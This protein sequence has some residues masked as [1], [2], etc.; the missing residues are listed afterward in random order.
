MSHAQRPREYPRLFVLSCLV[1]GLA[2]GTGERDL[3]DP[4]WR[5][6]ARQRADLRAA[7][8][9]EHSLCT[10]HPGLPCL[11]LWGW[12]TTPFYQR[13]AIVSPEYVEQRAVEESFRRGANLVEL[14]RGGFPLFAR[15]GW[16]LPRTRQ[17]HRFIHERDMLVQWFPHSITDAAFRASGDQ[18]F[19]A[20][21]QALVALG[22][23]SYDALL[24]PAEE[25]MDGIGSEKWYTMPPTLFNLCFW[26]FHPGTFY[27]TNFHRYS[28]TLPNEMD[29]TASSGLGVD[30]QTTTIPWMPN[31]PGDYLALVHEVRKEHGLQFWASQA[32]ARSHLVGGLFGGL[33]GPAWVLKQSNDICRERA[34]T[35][36]QRELS[37]SAIWWINEA[38]NV[39]P[40]AMREYV[41][42]ISQDP[43]R[44]AVSAELGSLGADAA[45]GSRRRALQRHAQPAATAF[46][47]NNYFRL[48]TLPEGDRN[49]LLHDPERLAHYD[50]DSRTVRLAGPLLETAWES[51]AAAHV[52]AVSFAHLE[53][54][55][56]RAVQE[57][58][59]HFQL[60]GGRFSETRT[61]TLESD[62][63]C[64]RLTLEREACHG[65]FSR[66][67]LPVY[68]RLR[69]DGRLHSTPT[70]LDPPPWM[71]LED[72]AGDYPALLLLLP[73]A[74]TLRRLEWVPREGLALRS[75]SGAE[76]FE[77]A[78]ALP[79]GLYAPD[80][81]GDLL[82]LLRRPEPALRLDD[83][84]RVVV[85]NPLPIPRVRVV[86]LEGGEVGPFH[87][88]EFGAWRV[89]GAQPSRLQPD[90]ALVK[91][92]LPPGGEAVVERY[93]W[94]GGAVRPGWGCQYTLSVHE[95]ESARARTRVRV[96]A[97][98]VTAFLFAPRLRFREPVA[99]VRLNGRPWAYFD[100][101]HV[102]LPN[103]RGSYRLEVW[104]GPPAVPRLASTFAAIE[105]ARSRSDRLDFTAGLPPWTTSLPEGF[106]FT[107]LVRHPGAEVTGLENAELVRSASGQASILRF[108][109][110]K[111][112]VAFRPSGTHPPLSPAVDM[113]AEAIRFLRQEGAEDLLPY[114]GAFQTRMISLDEPD[115]VA[116]IRN[117]D[118]LLFNPY[119]T[120]DLPANLTA[121]AR[122]AL[123]DFV[124]SGGGLL[125]FSNGVRLA[126]DLLGAPAGE[127]ALTPL[128][129]LTGQ[130]LES[131]GFLPAPEA[132]AELL[133]GLPR[134]ATHAAMIPLFRP[135]RFDFF[136]WLECRDFSDGERKGDLLG[137]VVCLAP[138]GSL[139]QGPGL[140]RWRLGQG[141]LLGHPAGLRRS[142]GS[143]DRYAP[144][145]QERRLVENL[146]GL[147][148]RQEN[149]NLLLGILW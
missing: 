122:S 79:E 74:G 34:R 111:V 81:Y 10:R 36:G 39:T 66:M 143:R 82:A 84:G 80:R 71:L 49:L 136:R 142:Y 40:D 72:S 114:L 105:S 38:D 140:W 65:A 1:W 130:E 47:Q 123:Q 56:Y 52:A 16:T 4:A 139:S 37:P 121:S 57:A 134:H 90:T 133:A 23:D 48:L 55:G 100:G 43:I 42:G 44:C 50:A 109:P 26:P 94:I 83:G 21:I 135:D 113:H 93:G 3:D 128:R 85:H 30:D 60:A 63:P 131:V 18:N 24:T 89:R 116:L 77:L 29:I 75:E 31:L 132:P 92:Y 76:R 61:W 59:L 97:E 25:L 138:D 41:Y 62:T 8:P 13:P 129:A 103:R 69:A 141:W 144:S 117:C 127:A 124:A 68:D 110:G 7:R 137:H 54:A 115:F 118:A 120:E 11:D 148:T 12:E 91:C 86:A 20:S 146:V 119:Y 99:G 19:E 27:Y 58:R 35:R 149:R 5:D 95:A 107:A 147:T 126:P 51:P 64:L 108:R 145:H 2:W 102:F 96:E 6:E 17:L 9:A 22:R 104:H 106:H 33:A 14:Y 101:C 45:E 125:L 15:G 87:V 67:A 32:E 28:F 88:K 78:L 73:D 70:S 112:A 53:P 46:I 98:A